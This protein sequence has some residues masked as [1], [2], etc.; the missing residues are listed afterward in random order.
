[1]KTLLEQL[2]RIVSDTNQD[3]AV[4]ME[5]WAGILE[6]I[7]LYDAKHDINRTQSKYTLTAYRE[8]GVSSCRG[9]ITGRS[10]SDFQLIES[11]DEETFIKEW[12]NLIHFNRTREDVYCEY[13]FTLFYDG[14]V[15]QSC[16]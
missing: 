11:D 9:C 8:D 4:L 1:M 13:E 7:A 3:P 16:D 2:K 15:Q 14:M 10:G 12:A 6:L 5:Q